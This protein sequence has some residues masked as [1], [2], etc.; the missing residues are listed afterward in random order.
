MKF[1]CVVTILLA[2]A[3]PVFAQTPESWDNYIAQYDDGPGSVTLNM[4]RKETAP[5]KALPFVLV[6]GLTTT[7]DCE[8][9]GF[10]G[11]KELDKLQNANDAAVAA[12]KS[13]TNS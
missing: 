4:V 13:V 5:V 10:P 11:K 12:V 2:F 6:T 3:A 1:T 8:Q 7:K 9:D